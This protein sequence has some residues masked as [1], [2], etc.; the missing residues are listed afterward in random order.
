[1]SDSKCQRLDAI[2]DRD[3]MAE[4]PPTEEA[5]RRF[6]TPACYS[7]LGYL[8]RQKAKRNKIDTV[9]EI[10]RGQ[11]MLEKVSEESEGITEP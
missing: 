10:G 8:A 1:M 6:R 7:I 4:N 9:E 11:R 3:Q 5:S 2:S